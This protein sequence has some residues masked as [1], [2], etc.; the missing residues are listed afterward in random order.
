MTMS[1]ASTW[2]RREAIHCGASWNGWMI[3][4]SRRLIAQTDEYR[5]HYY[6][7]YTGG[8]YWTNPVNYDL[9]FNNAR[10]GDER[11]VK[12]TLDC[13]KLKFGDDFVEYM[14][15]IGKDI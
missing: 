5:A 12:L 1:S 11:C 14:K 9:T 8:N 15:S 4:R 10:L 6:K 2:R 3:S 13:M 7:Y